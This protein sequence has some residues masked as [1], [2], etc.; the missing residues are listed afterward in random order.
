ML[1]R[2]SCAFACLVVVAASVVVDSILAAA[3]VA[4]QTAH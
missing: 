2:I 4:E 3:A 1:Q